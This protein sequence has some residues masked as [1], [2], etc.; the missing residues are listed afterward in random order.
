M[1]I[2]IF[3]DIKRELIAKNLARIFEPFYSKSFSVETKNQSIASYTKK[4]IE[5]FKEFHPEIKHEDI[6]KHLLVVTYNLEKDLIV[7]TFIYRED[8]ID[9]YPST[10]KER[11][12]WFVK[13]QHW[14][15]KFVN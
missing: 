12:T 9:K 14:N 2:I 4:K 3:L 7:D 5:I 11:A 13:R 6:M 8:K 10:F 15:Y 1:V